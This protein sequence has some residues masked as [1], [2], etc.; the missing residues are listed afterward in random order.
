MMHTCPYCK[1]ISNS[2]F[3]THE[4]HYMWCCACDLIYLNIQKSYNDVV[5]TYGESHSKRHYVDQIDG[6]RFRLY[7]HILKLIAENAKVGKIL[8]V[9]TGYGS[10]L[11]T[12][13]N[14]GWDTRGVEPSKQS[15]SFARRQNNLDIFT[16]TLQKYAANCQFNVI[17]FINVLDQSHMP[18]LEID[19][20]S[21]LLQPG[22]LIYLRFPNGFLHSCL[23]RMAQKCGLS[24]P[25]R[26]FLI[27]HI[28]SFTPRYVRK[29]LCDHGF[30]QIKIFNS[31]SSLGDPHKI[32]PSPSF[33]T[34]VKTVIYFIAKFM[35]KI[36]RGQLFVG[37]S[38][39]VTAVKSENP[40]N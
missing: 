20:A 17:T 3:T 40:H 23:F 24:K 5:A 2:Y 34:Y 36:S 32:F 31:P 19:L 11:V 9:G 8:D 22:G 21:K 37:T 7:D 25:L 6:S 27:F 38:L 13:R 29:L 18:W 33:A 26:K 12:A 14:R 10:F 4:R 16:G 15:V 1:N 28:Y 30:D 39:E 35:E